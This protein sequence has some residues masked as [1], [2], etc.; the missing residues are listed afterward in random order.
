MLREFVDDSGNRRKRRRKPADQLIFAMAAAPGDGSDRT[1]HTATILPC[2]CCRSF[3]LGSARPT[4]P[5]GSIQVPPSA[6]KKIK[7]LHTPAHQV[8]NHNHQARPRAAIL[9]RCIVA[10][11]CGPSPPRSPGVLGGTPPGIVIDRVI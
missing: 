10:A 8:L 1:T 2:I 9:S 3:T 7:A 6:S 5:L 4:Q 11:R